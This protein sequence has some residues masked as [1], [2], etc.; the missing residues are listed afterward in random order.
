MSRAT[1]A[2]AGHADPSHPSPSARQRVRALRWFAQGRCLAEDLD[3]GHTFT[4]YRAIPGEISAARPVFDGHRHRW[5]AGHPENPSSDRVIPGCQAFSTCSGCAYLHLS[6]SAEQAAKRQSA[7]E[8]LQ[9]F[10][11]VTVHPDAFTW[12]GAPR[13]P[14]ERTRATLSLTHHPGTG[15]VLGMRGMD[16]SVVDLDTCPALLP[17]LDDARHAL[18]TSARQAG[19]KPNTPWTLELHSGPRSST[20]ASGIALVASCSEPE[21]H[22]P[23]RAFLERVHETLGYSVRTKG[24]DPAL[25]KGA[26]PAPWPLGAASAPEAEDTWTP[27]TPQR[28]AAL[29]AWVQEHA[30][31]RGRNVIDLTLGRGLFALT[32]AEEASQVWGVDHNHHACA[33]TLAW[34]QQRGIH[35]LTLRPGKA[36]TVLPRLLREGADFDTVLLNPM[37]SSLGETLMQTITSCRADTLLYLA[38]APRAGAEDLRVLL[39]TGW[40]P[41]TW[42]IADLHPGTASFLLAACLRRP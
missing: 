5:I 42:S 1:A 21:E 31:A 4:V 27:T 38:P 36:T 19:L 14:G 40:R 30:R 3:D 18:R 11:N 20:N 26:W 34:A 15:P 13:G 6:P 41:T 12:C 28:Y 7:S 8:I 24:V 2:A 25:D 22:T 32:L 33:A 17:T 10:A 16:G 37:R 29:V 23:L 39:A 9:R 35:N